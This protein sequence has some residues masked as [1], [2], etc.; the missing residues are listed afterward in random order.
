MVTMTSSR[1]FTLAALATAVVSLAAC[2]AGGRDA[3]TSATSGGRAPAFTDAPADGAGQDHGD[4]AAEA[5]GGSGAGSETPSSVPTV[6]V[7][8]PGAVTEPGR[9]VILTGSLDLAVP[10]VAP[11]VAKVI[12]AVEGLG[13]LVVGEQSDYASEAATSVVTVKVPPEQFRPA[14]SALARLGSV[15]AETVGSEDVTAAVVDLDSRIRTASVSV[16]RLRTYLAEAKT[17]ADVAALEGE[18]LRRETDLEALRGQLRTIKDRVALAT[19]VVTL[20][21]GPLTGDTAPSG[22]R[23]GFSDAVDAGRRALVTVASAIALVV[24]A[25]VA[26]LPVLVAALLLVWIV[27]RLGRKPPRT[28]DAAPPPPAPPSEERE[29]ELVG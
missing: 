19:I 20:R 1:R 7:D 3:S 29:P 10:E 16:E 5:G 17:T 28:P 4:V 2:G 27:R 26:W 13:G 15:T 21:T 11:T 24:G 8:A 25:L 18:L 14:L 12:V 23:P 9:Q 22:D 6:P